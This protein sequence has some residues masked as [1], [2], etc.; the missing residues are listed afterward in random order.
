MIPRKKSR[1]SEMAA[2]PPFW[3]RFQMTISFS[4]IETDPNHPQQLFPAMTAV[5]NQLVCMQGRIQTDANDANA[6]VKI[7]KSCCLK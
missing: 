2:F 3:G 5:N 7:E 6:S 4:T 1:V